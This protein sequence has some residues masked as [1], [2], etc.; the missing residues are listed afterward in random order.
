MAAPDPTPTIVVGADGSDCALRAVETAA[1]EARALGCRLEIVHAF[2]W[3]E[4][5]VPE[6]SLVGG[7]GGAGLR[8]EADR[9]V[10]EAVELAR[11]AAP[12]VAVA[13]RVVTGAP[14]P[15]LLRASV[16][17]ALVVVGDRGLGGFTGLLVGS[18]AVALV[19]HGRSPVL[20]LRGRTAPA[21]PVVVGFDGSDGA[22][23]AAELALVYAAAHGSTL[24][25]VTVAPSDDGPAELDRVDGALRGFDAHGVTVERVVQHGD[26]RQ[27]L[28][29]ES[30]SASL[31]VVGSRGRGGFAGLLLGSVS[32]AVLHHADCPVAVLPR[33]A[34]RLQLV[35]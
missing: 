29:A 17:A 4:L 25:V 30:R 13:G 5:R 22:L 12:D 32:Q 28:I 33:D 20:V 35:R 34:G 7:S 9:I 15:V 6:G 8:H 24:R 18:V 26:A 14:A 2:V 3:P 10:A 1:A 21:G 11:R 19:T 27:T 16:D 31:V 23:P